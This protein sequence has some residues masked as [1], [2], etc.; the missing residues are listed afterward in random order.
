MNITI[1]LLSCSCEMCLSVKV[2]ARFYLVSENIVLLGYIKVGD[3]GFYNSDY[4]LSTIP[5][6]PAKVAG[7]VPE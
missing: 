2:G 1:V 4:V 7:V 3:C 6:S 5:T